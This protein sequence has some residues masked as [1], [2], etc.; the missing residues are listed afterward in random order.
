MLP[1]QALTGVGVQ[2]AAHYTLLE[3]FGIAAPEEEVTA[4]R[5]MDTDYGALR[6]AAWAA[7]S[8]KDRH[9]QVLRLQSRQCLGQCSTATSSRTAGCC[10]CVIAEAEVGMQQWG[11]SGY[12]WPCFALMQH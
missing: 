9:A 5:C 4:T 11:S 2:V 6:D 1:G 7:E 8:A 12:L 10:G 3:E